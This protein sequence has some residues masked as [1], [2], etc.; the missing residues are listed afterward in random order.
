MWFKSSLSILIA[1]LLTNYLI[2]EPKSKYLDFFDCF[3]EFS[4]ER[5]VTK[6]FSL[7]TV[8]IKE[9]LISDYVCFKIDSF[10]CTIT[11]RD[12]CYFVDLPWE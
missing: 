12:R 6:I 1:Q 2:L 10:R 3:A 5:S 7:E 9:D 8:G 11:S 4:I